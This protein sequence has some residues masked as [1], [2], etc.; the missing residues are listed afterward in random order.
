[1]KSSLRLLSMGLI[2]LVS[3]RNYCQDTVKKVCFNYTFDEDRAYK[4]FDF[5]SDTLNKYVLLG[6]DYRNDLVIIYVND[7]VIYN[8]YVHMDFTYGYT[9][10]IRLPNNGKIYLKVN[11]MPKT[12][13]I[14]CQDKNYYIIDYFRIEDKVTI[15]YSKYCPKIY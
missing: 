6:S 8:R 13:L 1:M 12:E 11:E 5:K 3:M 7:S 9:D 14:S 15:S 2:M 4:G 10:L